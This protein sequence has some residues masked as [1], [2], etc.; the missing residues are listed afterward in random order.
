MD[1]VFG[2]HPFGFLIRG[3]PSL[4][5]E[6][7][8]VDV[9]QGFL[10]ALFVPDRMAGVAGGWS[11]WYAQRPWTMRFRIGAGFG[12]GRGPMGRGYRRR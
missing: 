5:S 12:G 10:L 2:V 11:E 4:V 8:I 6:G 9:D 7:D 1:G 3:Q